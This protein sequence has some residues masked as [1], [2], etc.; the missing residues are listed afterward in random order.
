MPEPLLNPERIIPKQPEIKVAAPEQAKEIIPQ[1]KPA[2]RIEESQATAPL[3]TVASDV[4]K[5]SGRKTT[6]LQKEV[7]GLLEEGL[8][9]FYQELAPAEQAEFR[10]QGEETAIKITDL[11]SKAAIKVRDII[12]LIRDWLKVITGVNKY[13]LEQEAKIKADKI[14]KLH[15]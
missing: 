11:L 3:K 5:A 15:K 13:F 12:K 2:E 8:G 10:R 1:A 7:E 4:V 9:D 6:P 14:L